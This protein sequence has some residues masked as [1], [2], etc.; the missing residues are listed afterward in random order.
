M[1]LSELAIA[2]N[3]PALDGVVVQHCT[4]VFNTTRNA[5]GGEV[6]AEVDGNQVVA[7]LGS[8]VN[9]IKI[10]GIGIVSVADIISVASSELAVVIITKA[11]GRK[12]VSNHAEVI[13]SAAN[14]GVCRG[15]S[16]ERARKEKREPNKARVRC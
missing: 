2:I 9:V 7:H 14:R 6:G 15:G 10:V 5:L 16:S 8:K 13:I 11:H 1:L 12:V 4:R 3:T